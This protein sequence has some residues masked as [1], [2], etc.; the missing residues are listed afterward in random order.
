M[1]RIVAKELPRV[2]MVSMH[3]CVTHVPKKSCRAL[4]CFGLNDQTHRAVPANGGILVLGHDQRH[5]GFVG[6]PRC[7]QGFQRGGQ[8]GSRYPVIG[9][10]GRTDRRAT[11]MYN[12]RRHQSGRRF[13][14]FG[15]GGGKVLFGIP[16]IM[17]TFENVKR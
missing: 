8:Q 14:R 13:M 9:Q 7:S 16:D 5:D 15:V 2:K 6:G 12:W 17:L 10:K 1:Q 3:K 4:Y 11:V